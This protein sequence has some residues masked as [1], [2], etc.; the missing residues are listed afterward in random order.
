MIFVNIIFY[1]FHNIGRSRTYQ[2]F[3]PADKFTHD[4]WYHFVFS[5]KFGMGF[6]IYVDGCIYASVPEDQAA[7]YSPSPAGQ[8]ALSTTLG[9]SNRTIGLVV[10]A[11]DTIDDFYLWADHKSNLFA[12]QMYNNN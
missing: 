11:R 12:W 2:V 9:C 7:A 10:C 8:E 4:V 5:Y 6:A 1:R 3:N